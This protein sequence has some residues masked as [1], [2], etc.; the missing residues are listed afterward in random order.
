MAFPRSERTIY[1][2]NFISEAVCEV[3]FPRLL[4]IDNQLPAQF[5][6]SLIEDFP[7]FESRQI[8][9]IHFTLPQLDGEVVSA[10]QNRKTIY[11]FSREDKSVSINLSSESVGITTSN[12]QHWDVFSTHIT[13]AI[14]A[15][16]E[17]YG[18]SRRTRIGLRYVNS[19]PQGAPDVSWRTL[20][21][22]ALL[23]ILGE[24]GMGVEAWQC[25]TSGQIDDETG[26]QM[27]GALNT[28]D[29]SI[30]FILDM[31]IFRAMPGSFDPNGI[32]SAVA[33][34]NHRATDAFNWA[35]G[36]GLRAAMNT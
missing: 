24:E 22:P 5:Q 8:L 26:M 21:N 18:I 29:G 19:I 3:R 4:E 32:L 11:S 31:D 7:V 6:K 36:P 35:A 20:I 15:A 28:V 30:S 16:K 12:Y 1:K 13:R 27:I 10:P 9:G 34:M 25:I 33:D 17:C 2:R 23:G 14:S